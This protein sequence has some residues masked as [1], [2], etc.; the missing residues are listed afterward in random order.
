MTNWFRYLFI[1]GLLLLLVPRQSELTLAQTPE[2]T[3]PADQLYLALNQALIENEELPLARNPVLDVVAQ[4]LADELSATGSYHAPLHTAVV[5]LGFQRW[6]DNST[7]ISDVFNY[8]GIDSLET[9]ARLWSPQV[10]GFIAQFGYREI[11]LASAE[12]VAVQ[13]GTVQNVYVAIL[14]AQ[15]NIIP[16]VINDGAPI[17]YTPQV[18]LYIHGE[19]SLAYETAEDVV[20]TV[21]TFRLAN[22]EAELAT[23]K[24]LSWEDNYFEYEWQLADGFGPKEIW[25]EVADSKGATAHFVAQVEYAD[26]AT[27][28]TPLD[29]SSLETPPVRLVMTYGSDTFTLQVQ[30]EASTVNLQEVYFTWLDDLRVYNLKNANALSGVNLQNFSSTDCLEIRLR[31]LESVSIEGCQQVFLEANEF[32]ELERVFWNPAFGEFRVFNGSTLPGACNTLEARCE[33]NYQ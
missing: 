13:G 20:Q 10:A 8:I 15:P 27:A 32:T 9:V 18:Q 33:V 12:R 5:D 6:P 2:T 30:T 25:V 1:W 24:V 29:A 7:R 16:V 17:V 11:G 28:P 23:A 21:Q 26:P 3:T 22:S 14:G 19:W 4:G 31:G